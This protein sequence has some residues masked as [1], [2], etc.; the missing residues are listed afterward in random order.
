MPVRHGGRFTGRH[1]NVSL[2][3]RRSSKLSICEGPPSGAARQRV[4]PSMA[5]VAAL[6]SV[7][8]ADPECMRVCAV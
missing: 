2:A 7:I 1:P 4:S 8:R 3:V 6:E 5:G